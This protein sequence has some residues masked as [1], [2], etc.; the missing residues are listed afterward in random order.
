MC[1]SQAF[2]FCFDIDNTKAALFRVLSQSVSFDGLESAGPNERIN[3]PI[4][5]GND[6]VWQYDDCRDIPELRIYNS[7]N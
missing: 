1:T 7:V 6:C 3:F 5:F 4:D 2:Q